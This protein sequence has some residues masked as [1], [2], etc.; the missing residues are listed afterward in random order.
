MAMTG[1]GGRGRVVSRR[2]N[3]VET[4]VVF[5][6]VVLVTAVAAGLL[7]RAVGA[8]RGAR[9]TS[10][11]SVIESAE[12]L[13]FTAHGRYATVEELLAG[14][15]MT[16]APSDWV[17]EVVDGGAGYRIV[18]RPEVVPAALP[19]GSGDAAEGSPGSGGTP[20]PV[21]VSPPGGSWRSG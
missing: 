6:I 19:A 16:R 3:L 21:G 11:R 14:D 10:E 1:T 7:N 9:S 15:F 4:L 5:A 12:K 13:H 8:A 17:V 2:L 18:P 20:A